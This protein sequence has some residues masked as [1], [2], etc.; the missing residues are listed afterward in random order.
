MRYSLNKIKEHGADVLSV[1]SFESGI[2]LVEATINAESG[3]IKNSEG[4]NLTFHSVSEAKEAFRDCKITEMW[5]VEETAYDE[6]CGSSESHSAPM[7]VPLHLEE[8]L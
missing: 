6:M 7:R 4:N 8:R 3:Y 2:Y 5:L 1:H